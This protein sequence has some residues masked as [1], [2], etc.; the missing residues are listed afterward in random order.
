MTTPEAPTENRGTLEITDP[1]ATLKASGLELCELAGHSMEGLGRLVTDFAKNDRNLLFV[2]EPGTGKELLADIFSKSSERHKHSFN[3][4]GMSENVA[5][6]ALFGHV[7]EAFTGATKSREGLFEKAKNGFIFLDELGASNLGD[8][9]AQLLRV[10]ETGDYLPLGDDE[11]KHIMNVS[12]CSAT[13]EPQNIRQ[14][15]RDRFITLYIPPLRT[16]P[17]DISKLLKTLWG[18]ENV[19]DINY[20]SGEALKLLKHHLWPGNVRELRK[21]IQVAIDLARFDGSDTIRLPHLPTI[22]GDKTDNSRKFKISVLKSGGAPPLP[23][24]DFFRPFAT[25]TSTKEQFWADP[26]SYKN[27][28]YDHYYGWTPTELHKLYP[29][30]KRETFRD[31][32]AR[33]KRRNPPA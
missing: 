12:V 24:D 23:R 27:E 17:G 3:C 18:K 32:L 13:S 5:K 8:F 2:G 11:V 30:G 31:G 20:V 7:K 29:K 15:L 1:P 26:E 33:D 9:Q 16:R 19:D 10:L 22:N 25:L 14:D 6:S 21:T 28:F 4:A